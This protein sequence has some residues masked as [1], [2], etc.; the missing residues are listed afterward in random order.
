MPQVMTERNQ[1]RA[2]LGLGG[3]I[4]HPLTHFRRARQQLAAHPQVQ[5]KASSPLYSTPPVGGP[6]GQPDFMNA[7][8]EIDTELAAVELLLFCQQ[9]E[10]ESGRIRTVH[11]GPRPLDIDLLFVDNQILDSNQLTLPHPRLA[12]RHFVLRPLCDLAPQLQHPQLQCSMLELL[13]KLPPE[14][15]IHCLHKA[16]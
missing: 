5:L 8:L 11:W 13:D 4:D 3:N 14:Q 10:H 6:Q 9:L 16:W 15:G 12:E 1:S 2:F 7:V